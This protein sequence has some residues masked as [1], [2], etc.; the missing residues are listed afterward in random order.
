M[1]RN[2]QRRRLMAPSRPVR[3]VFWDSPGHGLSMARERLFVNTIS[4]HIRSGHLCTAW[5][6]VF[7]TTP[8]RVCEL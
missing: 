8:E 4:L 1:A 7:Q 5:V 3:P 6:S 2:A